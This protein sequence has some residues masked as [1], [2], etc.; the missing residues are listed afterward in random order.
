MVDW[1]D[2]FETVAQ[3]LNARIVSGGVMYTTA[4]LRDLKDRGAPDGGCKIRRAF[5]T[6]LQDWTRVPAARYLAAFDGLA[7]A[8]SE[9]H[10]V[11]SLRCGR[12]DF[13][14]PALVLL[15]GLFP[16]VPQALAYAFTPRPLEALCIPLTRCGHWSVAMPDMKG[17]YNARFR[18]PSVEALTWTSLFPSARR[19]W[20]SVHKAA[21]QGRMDLQLPL[22]RLRVVAYG[23]R[24]GDTV[25][26]TRLVVNALV[27]QEEPMAFAAGACRSFVLMT[28]SEPIE[29]GVN[30]YFE[31]HE[32]HAA[33]RLCLSD[34]EW[35][36]LEPY[37]E[38]QVPV[39]GRAVRHAPRDVADGLAIRAL[40]ALP[41]AEIPVPVAGDALATHAQRWRANGQWE[42]LMAV[43][44]RT[45]GTAREL[46]AVAG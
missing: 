43:L 17:W 11:F 25:H 34:Q 20:H 9:Q 36:Q 32:E 12:S 46:L 18:R 26:V 5:E 7:P 2:G 35:A 1:L 31:S 23:L 27:A 38:R 28:N 8:A 41:W 33:R 6:N 14:V 16:L 22:A 40:T 3:R 13:L 44:R 24:A 45:R 10:A 37:C 39:R 42:Q 30:A 21:L 15:R 29:P 19:A 4:H